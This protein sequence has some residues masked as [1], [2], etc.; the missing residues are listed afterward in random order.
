MSAKQASESGK[1]IRVMDVCDLR[2]RCRSEG[3]FQAFSFRTLQSHVRF[4]LLSV[5]FISCSF[6]NGSF[7]C[8]EISG[9]MCINT[10]T[11]T[12]IWRITRRISAEAI[13]LR[14]TND[15]QRPF[16]Q[17]LKVVV[18]LSENSTMIKRLLENIQQHRCTEVEHLWFCLRLLSLKKI[19][20]SN[21]WTWAGGFIVF[22][23][24]HNDKISG[25]VVCLKKAQTEMTNNFPLQTFPRLEQFPP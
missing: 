18:V 5:V 16:S 14:G 20:T 24:K 1:G 15:K 25:V 2:F 19:H 17:Q 8:S 7:Y 4:F 11:I 21:S 23:T 10:T 3:H 13:V 22:T 9:V 6:V 12:P